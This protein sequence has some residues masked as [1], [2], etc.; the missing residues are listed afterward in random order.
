MD[1]F[2]HFAIATLFHYFIICKKFIMTNSYAIT[3]ASNYN[4]ITTYIATP[5]Q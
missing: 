1:N 4:Y 3:I 5:I 2:T